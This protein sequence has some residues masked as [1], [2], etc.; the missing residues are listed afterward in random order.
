MRVQVNLNENVVKRLDELANVMGVSR[1]A[2]C[3][4]WIGNSLL[5]H[6]KTYQSINDLTKQAINS[7]DE[8][9]EG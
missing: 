4:V 3:A 9:K 7:E 6:E 8:K 1:S 5:A 2:L